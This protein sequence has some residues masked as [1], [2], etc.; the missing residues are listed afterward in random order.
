M[1]RYGQG[2]QGFEDSWSKIQGDKADVRHDTGRTG[3]QD[4][5]YTA[6]RYTDG[7]RNIYQCRGIAT[8]PPFLQAT[9]IH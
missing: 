7:E 5:S 1:Y 9:C 4:G 3:S 8:V 6:Y 2:K